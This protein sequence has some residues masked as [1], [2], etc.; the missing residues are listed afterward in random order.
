MIR[1]DCLDSIPSSPYAPESALDQQWRMGYADGM[2]ND[3][4]FPGAPAPYRQGWWDGR[5]HSQRFISELT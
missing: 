1:P 4:M 3:P 2:D 5:K